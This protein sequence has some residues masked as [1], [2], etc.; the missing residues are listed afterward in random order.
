MR[1]GGFT[2]LLYAMNQRIVFLLVVLFL[3]FCLRAQNIPEPMRPARAVNDFAGML[4]SEEQVRLEQKLR[5]F[6]DSTSSALVIV[7]VNSLEGMNIAQYATELAHQWGIGREDVDNGLLILVAEEERQVNIT[8]G[9]GLEGAV[10]DALAKRIIE[11]QIKPRFRQGNYYGAL[12]AATETLMKLASGEYTAEEVGGGEEAEGSPW[13]A[14]LL[15]LFL[16]IFP[17]LQIR[18]FK[19][20]HMGTSRRSVGWL[21]MLLLMSGMNRHSGRSYQDFNS[22]GGIFGGGGGGGGGFGGFGGGGFGGGGASGS[23]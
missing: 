5:S 7:T 2:N 12:D 10:P 21:P 15:V 13:L 8:T 22:G 18:R 9:Y 14:L 20:R 19:N 4:S 16:I 3:P 23:W 6:N 17:I 11:E 1:P